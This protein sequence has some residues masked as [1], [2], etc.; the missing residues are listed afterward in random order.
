[1]ADWRGNLGAIVGS[2]FTTI[3]VAISWFV[4]SEIFTTLIAVLVGFLASYS[5]QTITQKRAWKREYS[6]KIVEE[7]YGSLFSGIKEIIASLNSKE[8]FHTDFAKW[9]QMQDDHRYFMVD[10]DFRGKLDQFLKRLDNQSRIITKLR[11]DVLPKIVLDKAKSVLR[12]VV[13]GVP[14][15]SVKY[16]KGHRPILSSPEFISCL[17]SRTHP[18]KHAIRNDPDASV[19]EL[20]YTFGVI[21]KEGRARVPTTYSS[22]SNETLLNTFWESC[23]NVM[24]EDESYGL[25]VR[26][27]ER[28]L[29]EAKRLKQEIVKRIEEP[30][31]I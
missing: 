17:I 20:S 25:V 12:R 7:V 29:E 8:Y 3:G 27:N 2:V 24:R 13:D 28:L 22:P 6:I 14:T 23:L 4:S 5:L 18:A 1:M 31:R 19:I 9:R 11:G 21:E 15:V 30:W 16:S 10:S 26:E